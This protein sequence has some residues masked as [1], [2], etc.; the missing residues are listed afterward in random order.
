MLEITRQVTAAA[1]ESLNEDERQALMASLEER[2]LA[3]AQNLEFEEAAKLRDQ[4]LKLRG[5]TPV[6]QPVQQ[7]RS[8]APRTRK[9]EH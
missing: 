2:M 5:E 3:A 9:S 1:P 4:L 8:R 7:R 6:K